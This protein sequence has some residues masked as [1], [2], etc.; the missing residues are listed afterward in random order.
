MVYHVKVKQSHRWKSAQVGGILFSQFEA[1]PVT[2]AQL[3]D[4]IRNS[5]L[6]DIEMVS[7]ELESVAIVGGSESDEDV[8]DPFNLRG[9]NDLNATNSAIELALEFDIDLAE[10]QG[11]G[12]KGRITKSDVEAYIENA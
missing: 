5:D 12:S 7:D 4:E 10:I 9:G 8:F 1:R 3:T 11:T 6:L 2:E